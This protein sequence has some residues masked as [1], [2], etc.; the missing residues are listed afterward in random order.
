MTTILERIN[1]HVNQVYSELRL[2]SKGDAFAYWYLMARFSMSEMEASDACSMGGPNDKGLDGVYFD[3]DRREVYCFQFKYSEKGTATFAYEDATKLSSTLAHLMD[4]SLMEKVASPTLQDALQE[5]HDRRKAGYGL[6]FYVVVLG[7]I[8]PEARKEI[9]RLTKQYPDISVIVQDA[10]IIAEFLPSPYG[11]PEIDVELKVQAGEWME[12][13]DPAYRSIVLTVAGKTLADLRRQHGDRLFARNVRYFLGFR[14]ANKGILDTL[15]NPRERSQFWFFHNGVTAVCDDYQLDK[16][17]GKVKVKNFQIVNGCQTTVTLDD[18]L[19]YYGDDNPGPTLLLRVIKTKEDEDFLRK[20][21]RYTNTQSQVTEQDLAS[22]DRIQQHIQKQFEDIG[23]FYERARGEWNALKRTDPR[24]AEKFRTSTGDERYIRNG[25]VAKAMMAFVGFPTEA[26]AKKKLQFVHSH[27]G[28]YYDQI[29]STDR[30][31]WEYLLAYQ[32][33]C[34]CEDRRKEFNAQF[35]AHE[36]SGF[37]D[38]KEEE[39][40][41]LYARQFILHSETHLVALLAEFIRER[42]ARSHFHHLCKLFEAGEPE[43]VRYLYDI[44]VEILAQFFLERMRDESFQLSRYFKSSKAWPELRSYVRGQLR[45]LARITGTDP[46]ETFANKL[47]TSGVP[48]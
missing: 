39:K 35:D 7:S 48:A 16:E 18:G 13:E 1:E 20:I 43:P 12:H 45:V 3:D 2:A 31:V 4:E 23:Y 25:D 36:K 40:E 17:N 27:V 6:V 10:S 8:T 32:L 33:L 30:P 26:K 41:Q 9:E 38:L 29:F 11:F 46:L 28:G 42:V 14:G 21:S 15:R 47:N 34:F 22:N 5:I 19:N 44:I 37:A 24:R